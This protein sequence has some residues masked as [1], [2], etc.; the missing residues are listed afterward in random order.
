MDYEILSLIGALFSGVCRAWVW[1]I[2]GVPLSELHGWA[3]ARAILLTILP[4]GLIWISPLLAFAAICTSPGITGDVAMTVGIALAV[5]ITMGA[6]IILR[7]RKSKRIAAE[8]AVDQAAAETTPET[9][10]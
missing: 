9:A 5:H 4:T 2:W 7:H 6:G 8:K 10:P 1:I 3:K